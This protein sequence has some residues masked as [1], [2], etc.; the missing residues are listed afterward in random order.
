MNK[1][2]SKIFTSFVEI[3]PYSV[4]WLIRWFVPLKKDKFFFI[5]MF[6]KSYGDSVR[7]LSDYVKEHHTNAE[8]IWAFSD[9]Y[10]DDVIC[11][12]KKVRLF[13][14]NY[15]YHIITSK[16][17][18]TNC[19]CKGMMLI[20]RKGQV[21]LQTWHG[22]A[23]K[24]IGEDAKVSDHSRVALFFRPDTLGTE[25][26]RT[27]LFISGSKFMTEVY[28]RALKYSKHIYETGMPRN[29]IFFQDR[30]DILNKVRE[31][32]GIEKDVKI[33]LY[34]PTFRPDGKFTYYDVD[35]VS[36]KEYFEKTTG[37]V[38]KIL[39]RLHSGLLGKSNEITTFFPAGTINATLYP[40]MQELLYASDVLVTDYSSSMFDFMYT[41]KPVIMYIPDREL[42]NR[43]FYFDLEALPFIKLNNNSEIINRL[44]SFDID[45][46]KKDIDG[47]IEK[48][49]SVDNGHSTE[50]VYKLMMEC[51]K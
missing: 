47:F 24:R 12:N 35:L 21:K 22:T 38:F 2:I 46:Y 15:Y 36:I 33:I 3:I 43:G 45:D 25:A 18:I 26:K 6:G 31:H 41:Y 39:V 14:F 1:Y 9:N 51:G 28:H 23:L 17:I 7:C 42:Y 34:A 40:D 10:F 19:T 13:S 30:P 11:D 48:I 16:Y 27:D 50:A 44:E 37:E 4:A 20:K 29:D 8:V 49:G 5:S 32:Y